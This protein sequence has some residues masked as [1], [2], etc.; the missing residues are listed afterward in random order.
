VA[1]RLTVPPN[2]SIPSSRL[3]NTSTYSMVRTGTYPTKG[4]A[5]DFVVSGKLSTTVTDRNVVRSTP[6][7]VVISRCHRN[8]H[9]FHQRRYLRCCRSPSL[10]GDCSV[11]QDD[12]T[13]PLTTVSGSEVISRP[14]VS[15]SAAVKMMGSSAYRWRKICASRAMISAEV[16]SPVAYPVRVKTADYGTGFNVQYTVSFEE[17]QA[18]KGIT[19]IARPVVGLTSNEIFIGITI[20]S[21][22]IDFFY[23]RHPGSRCRTVPSSCSSQFTRLPKAPR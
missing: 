23:D 19:V 1:Q 13:T 16:L 10:G 18:V 21:L 12:Q 8:E 4:K 14:S 3:A 22:V 7:V 2:H 20:H 17:Y 6:A 15:S 5:V 9:A 11:T